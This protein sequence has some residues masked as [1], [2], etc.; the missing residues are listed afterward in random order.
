MVQC[1]KCSSI[2]IIGPKYCVQAHGMD[3]GYQSHPI[4]HLDYLC[5]QCGYVKMTACKDAATRTEGKG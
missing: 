3:Y 2:R 4:E 1:P 5:A